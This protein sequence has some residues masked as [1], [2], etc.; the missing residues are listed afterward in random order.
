M[1]TESLIEQIKQGT[2]VE[3]CFRLLYEQ[4]RN[5]VYRFFQRKKLSPEESQELTQETFFSIYKG[6]S[7][8]RQPA[9]FKSWM[10]AITEN[11]W[12]RYIEMKKAQRRD[13]VVISLDEENETQ[14]GATSPWADRI[15]DSSPS[16]LAVSLQQEKLD[17]LRVAMQK[18]SP[19][20]RYCLHLLVVEEMS[21]QEI[22]ECMGLS[23]GAVKA[24]LHQAKL[25]LREMLKS[26]F[27]ELEDLGLAAK[28]RT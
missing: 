12:R 15:P 9:Q 14:E 16:Q 6:L 27:A 11:T 8:L 4:H 13:A 17:K 26:D 1:T 19:Q 7:D 18:L 20:R 3:A 10:F 21:Y 28:E 25:A 5:Q 23:T 22:A 24:H 2:E